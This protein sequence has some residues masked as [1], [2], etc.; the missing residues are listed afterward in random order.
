MYDRIYGIYE[1][2]IQRTSSELILFF[3]IVGIVGVLLIPCYRMIFSDRKHRR[4][5]ESKAEER[6]ME[7]MAQEQKRAQERENATL[8]VIKENS[9][10]IAGHTAATNTLISLVGSHNADMKQGIGRI[11]DK[12]EQENVRVHKRLDQLQDNSSHIVNILK[13]NKK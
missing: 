9:A 11:H 1:A 8:S 2:I 7:R 4:E 10:A 5:F 13:E 12:I 3:V 6:E